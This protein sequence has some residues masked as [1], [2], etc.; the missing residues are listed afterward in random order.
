MTLTVVM[1]HYV[2]R[3]VDGCRPRLN[4]LETG[5]FIGQLDYLERN[6][7]IIGADRLVSALRKE[8]PLPE[9]AALLTFDDGYREHAETVMPV[10]RD[11]GLSAVF[12]PAVQ[13]VSERKLLD[14][15]KI[16][17]VLGSIDRPDPVVEMIEAAVS[18]NTGRPDV[19]DLEV[20]RQRHR[21]ANHLDSAEVCFV[22]QM[23]QY[24]L[25][26]DLRPGLVDT[27]FRQV[28]GRAEANVADELYMTEAQARDL[29]AAGMT[30][31]NHGYSHEWMH[32]IAPEAQRREVDLGL[33]FMDRIGAGTSDWMMCY[34]YGASN[35][36]LLEILR[37]K[38][39][40]AGFTSRRGLADLD[41]SDPLLLSRLDTN[42]LPKTVNQLR[43]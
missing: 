37:A 34:P 25:P 30:V 32:V 23:L 18:A 6:Y 38:G 43:S 8:L 5:D 35:E 29:V 10:L 26:A 9:R 19:L 20:Y 33:A 16:H 36:S 14:V 12:F 24:G 3:M 11:R 42:D 22:K 21:V 7:R 4:V 28:I 17:Y 27:V 31:G 41:G 2:R 1:Y 15:N 39:C 40:A 13:A